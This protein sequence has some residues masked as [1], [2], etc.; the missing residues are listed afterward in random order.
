MRN[1]VQTGWMIIVTL[2]FTALG[3]KGKTDG[4]ALDVCGIEQDDT[5][6]E[7]PGLRLVACTLKE[8]GSGL[9]ESRVLVFAIN[10]SF[11]AVYANMF[12]ELGDNLFVD[13]VG[14]SGQHQSASLSAVWEPYETRLQLVP[15]RAVLG[16][17]IDL[18]C[19]TPGNVIVTTS[20]PGCLG[21]ITFEE[22][23][24]YR[25]VF[26]AEIYWCSEPC[27]FDTAELLRVRSDTVSIFRK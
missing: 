8:S 1:R 27:G 10:G 7:G 17:E 12:P 14:P 6:A 16:R 2:G 26:A 3:C 11:S 13:V 18:A 19:L 20:E 25:V 9:A 22:A 21:K 24:E 23:G 5:W 4:A 15:A